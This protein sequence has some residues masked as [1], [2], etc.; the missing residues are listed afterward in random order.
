MK[1]QEFLKNAITGGCA[2]ALLTFG[3]NNVLSADDTTKKKSEEDKNQ[4]FIS[5]WAENLMV[6]LD[7]TLDEK[8]RSNIMEASGRNCAEKYY[9]AVAL[10]FKGNVNALLDHLKKQFADVAE[11]DEKKGTIRLV[12][13]KFKSCFCPVVKGRSSLKSGTYCLCSQGWM[14]QVFGMVSGKKVDVRLEKTI[15][16]G[17]DCCIFNM[18]LS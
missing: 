8:T 16:R 18:S 6:I 15:L 14:K 4:E 7:Q 9:K 12:S 2:C 1:R 3:T 13:K 17:A 5:G 10:K 11:Y